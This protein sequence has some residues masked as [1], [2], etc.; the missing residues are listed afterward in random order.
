MPLTEAD[1]E[2]IALEWFAA[3]GYTHVH[4]GPDI[5][6]DMPGSER[7]SYQEVLLVGRLRAAYT[8]V[9]RGC[10]MKMQTR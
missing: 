2:Q 4:A 7:A 1:I 6:P 10:V 3:C 8:D 5:A 9:I